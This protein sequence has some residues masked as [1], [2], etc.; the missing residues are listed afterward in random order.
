[1]RDR[2]SSKT[3]LK[4]PIRARAALPPG[5]WSR[6]ARRCINKIPLEQFF[7]CGA[8]RARRCCQAHSFWSAPRG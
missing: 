2:A 7:W 3:Q 6:A 8:K 5:G 4:S 1:V